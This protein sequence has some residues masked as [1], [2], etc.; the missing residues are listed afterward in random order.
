[1][2]QRRAL[3]RQAQGQ[4]QGQGA[5]S[6][7]GAGTGGPGAKAGGGG[8]GRG[9]GVPEWVAPAVDFMRRNL[10]ATTNGAPPPSWGPIVAQS[11]AG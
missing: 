7:L 2:R 11:D 10:N 1:M 8:G 6:G 5:G 9:G 4:A 3:Q